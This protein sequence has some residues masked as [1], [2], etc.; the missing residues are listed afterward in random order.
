MKGDQKV[1][2]KD[3]VTRTHHW[4]PKHLVGYDAPKKEPGTGTPRRMAPR[5][6][7]KG[8]K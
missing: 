1:I 5:Q 2:P 4:V 8:A 6:P 3:M 7:A